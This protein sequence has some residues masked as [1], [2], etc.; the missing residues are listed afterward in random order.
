ML[1]EVNLTNE[2]VA[3]IYE[4]E[5][6]VW[7]SDRFTLEFM[8]NK[9]NEEKDIKYMNYLLTM[10]PHTPFYYDP[11]YPDPYDTDM[12][13]EE[14]IRRFDILTL[15]YFNYLK[16]YNEMMQMFIEDVNGY[17]D[18]YEFNV[19]SLYEHQKTAYIF[20]GDHGS[21]IQFDDVNYIYN[22]ELTN[23]EIRQKLLQ[24]IAFIY[25]P[26]NNLVTKEIDGKE[27][28]LYEGMLKGEQ[29]LVRDQIDLY[30]TIIDLFNLPISS[31]DFLFGVN[32]LSN[33]PTYALDNKSLN[34]ITDNFVGNIRNGEIYRLNN[35]VE[36]EEINKFKHRVIKFKKSSDIAI[37]N[38]LYKTFYE[39]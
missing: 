7:S 20:Y 30:R 21:S 3:E 28:T 29:N 31:N 39:E 25:V 34:I 38:N 8:N 15:K 9:M 23:L 22:N 33:E 19:N 4:H 24:T 36:L 5:V 26:G 2:E 10:L 1:E 32:G 14:L 13:D 6:G 35:Q 18:D 37:N 27:L 17:G 12:Y 11:F 16:Y